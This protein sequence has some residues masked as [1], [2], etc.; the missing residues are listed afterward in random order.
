M[1]DNKNLLT[2]GALGSAESALHGKPAISWGDLPTV[3]S[4]PARRRFQ[5][6][7]LLN[8]AATLYRHDLPRCTYPLGIGYLAAVLERY[9]YEVRLLDVF[10]EGYDNAREV[11]GD[12]QF[13]R[14]GLDDDAI[15][16][17]LREFAPDVVG[18][19]SIFSNQADNV[20]HLL[21]LA[22]RVVPEAKTAMGGAHARYFPKACLEDPNLDVVFLGE[23]ELTFLLWIEHLNGSIAEDTLQGLAYRD[24]T[25]AVRIKPELPLIS[26]TRPA[27]PEVKRE[28]PILG[29]DG[30]LDHIPFPAWH[31]Y[32]ME[33]Y[34]EIK[35]Y[36]SPYTV[37]SRVGQVYTSRGCTAHCTFCTTTHFWGQK[38]RRR[39]VQNVVD[40]IVAL[41]DRYGIDEFHIQDDN[42]TNDMDHARELFKAF[43]T[44]GLPWATPQ[45]T[46]LWRMDEELLDLMVESGA[47]QVTFAI[48]SG[49]QRVLKE[50]IR[51]PLNLA[52]TAHLIRYARSI[53]MHVHGFFIIG[54][55]PMFGNEGESLAEMQASYDYAEEAG[56]SSASFFAASPI[57]GSELLREC[58][59]QRFVDADE[60]L[61]RM[62]YKQGIINV[63]GLWSGEE[64]AAL[65]AKFNANFNAS[66]VR[67]YSTRQWNSDKY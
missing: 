22:D 25:G 38:L 10:A 12:P 65:A 34:F 18:V 57:V 31:L 53:G 21:R 61:Y 63:P 2:I 9:G 55:P 23:G 17:V 58:I 4:D 8:P 28:S 49:V 13:L 59:R 44:I 67:S 5:K 1:T 46:A 45:G 27:G 39:S 19:S 51:K 62:T 14:Y 60:A 26:S 66:R 20:H 54:M 24:A 56:F 37:G 36:Q 50:L 64:V 43:R 29:A 32:N 48:E 52:R 40:E 42:I 15:V 11:D 47:Y 35:A 6:I 3:A 16:T 7:L 30:E 41:R 33:R